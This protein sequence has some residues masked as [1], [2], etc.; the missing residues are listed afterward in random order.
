MTD[1]PIEQN[2]APT[3]VQVVEPDAQATSPE[4]DGEGDA[5]SRAVKRSGASVALVII[6][7]LLWYLAADRFTPYTTQARVEGYVVGVAPKVAGLVTQVWVSNNRLIEEG[8]RLFEIDPAQYQIAVDRARSDLENTRR[9][10]SA[11]DATV[12]SARAKLRAAQP[13]EL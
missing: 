4:G 8:D 10:V 9:Q 3:P 7:S 1:R 13:N 5:A 6:L 12:A 11:G 2:D